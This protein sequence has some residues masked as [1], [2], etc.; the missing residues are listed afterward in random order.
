MDDKPTKDDGQ[1][2][3]GNKA[4]HK[5]GGEGAIKR[6]Q[7]GQELVGIA[8]EAEL[9]VYDELETEGRYALVVRN[10]ARLQAV[11]DLFWDA[12][13]KAAQD[14]NLDA[15]DRYIKR[16]GWLASLALR[17]L[18]QMKQE[19]PDDRGVIDYERMLAAQVQDKDK[20]EE[21]NDE[22]E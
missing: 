18:A 11:A 7:R 20:D 22:D 9:A 19:Q 21:G 6:V 1:F 12:V 10:A 3:P 15:L 13:A 4:A 17:A 5:H 16:Y 2:K 14:G 8:R